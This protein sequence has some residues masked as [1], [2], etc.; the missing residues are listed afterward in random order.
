MPMTAL[1]QPPVGT[2]LQPLVVLGHP[3]AVVAHDSDV[4]LRICKPLVRRQPVPL[5]RLLLALGHPLIPSLY[6]SP[7]ANCASAF[8]WSAASLL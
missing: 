3:H 8:P 7:R 6:I 1:G 5:D 2:T 4:V